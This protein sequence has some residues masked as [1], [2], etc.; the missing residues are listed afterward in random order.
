M[1][2]RG[3]M[4]MASGDP[5]KNPPNVPKERS[6]LRGTHAWALH[7]RKSGTAASQ[8]PWRSWRSQLP[9]TLVVFE[10]DLGS[11]LV[12]VTDGGGPGATRLRNTQVEPG[13]SP[14]KMSPRTTK[15]SC[16]LNLG[17]SVGGLPRVPTNGSAENPGSGGARAQGGDHSHTDG[18]SNKV[19]AVVVEVRAPASLSQHRDTSG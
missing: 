6:F 15:R 3:R 10:A 14:H 2:S 8:T 7:T 9:E 19:E 11:C 17:G 5:G 16:S 13:R 4:L 1:V 12:C 18:A